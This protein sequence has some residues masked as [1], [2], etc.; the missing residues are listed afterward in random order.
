MTGAVSLGSAQIVSGT[1]GAYAQGTANLKTASFSLGVNSIK[2][3]FAGTKSDAT[4]TSSAKT[5]TVTG[6]YATT[7]GLSGTV[8]GTDFTL[9]A[10]LR[11]FGLESP[12]GNVDFSHISNGVPI[13]T[14][15]TKS[16]TEAK[17][18]TDLSISNTVA[19]FGT[20]SFYTDSIAVGDFDGDGLLDVAASILHSAGNPKIVILPGNGDGSFKPPVSFIDAGK[21]SLSIYAADV[22][23]DGRLDL[24]VVEGGG[25]AEGGSS[26]IGI[27]LGNGDGTFQ[28]EVEY[29]S[30]NRTDGFMYAYI[31][32]LNRD[33]NLDIVSASQNSAEVS[34]VVLLGNGDGTFQPQAAYDAGGAASSDLQVVGG[35]VNGDGI[36]DLVVNAKDVGD[37]VSVLLGKGDGSFL[38]PHSYKLG[39]SYLELSLEVTLADVNGDGKLDIVWAAINGDIGVAPGTGDGS[40][41]TA[42]TYSLGGNAGFYP[43]GKPPVVDINQDG[44][45]D[46]VVEVEN[47]PDAQM[48][49]L[50]GKGDGTFEQPVIYLQNVG[51]AV[52]GESNFTGPV[53]AG[54]FNGDGRLDLVTMNIPKNRVITIL[55]QQTASLQVAKNEL[56]PNTTTVQASYAGDGNFT[57]SVSSAVPLSQGGVD[58][59][60]GFTGGGAGL[61]LNDGAAVA[62]G[63]LQLTNGGVNRTTSAYSATPVNIRQFVTDFTFQMSNA[64]PE[65]LTFVIQ[66][67]GP[68]AVGSPGGGLG[69][70]GIAK[71]IG[72]KFD[73]FNYCATA[74]DFQ[75]G[76][77]STGLYVDGPNLADSCIGL[78]SNFSNVNLGSGNP[79]QAHITY[80]GVYL[81]MTLTDTVTLATYGFLEQIDIPYKVAGSTAYVGF[82]GATGSQSATATIRSWRYLAETPPPHFPNYY[83]DA[84]FQST[85]ELQFNGTSVL[86]QSPYSLAGTVALTQGL[87]N[88]AGSIFYSAPQ[89]V[90]AFTTDFTF[91]VAPVVSLTPGYLS[92]VADGITFTIQN[93][94]PKALGGPGGGLG[95]RDI[96]KSVAIKFDFLNNSGEGNASTGLYLNG[97][98]PTVPAVDLTGSDF[99]L[100]GTGGE[101]NAHMTYDGAILTLTMVNKNT[102]PST[103]FTHSW[104]VDIPAAVGGTTA[105]VGFTGATGSQFSTD[106]L[107]SWT[108]LPGVN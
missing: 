105:Y 94:G 71:S 21:Y 18:G 17:W 106:T 70:Q 61:H 64:G 33:G 63:V 22:N 38:P 46:I 27:L 88:Q 51:V 68:G 6:K 100:L 82:T 55:N 54:D 108:Y 78:P 104:A 73:L 15:D 60:G 44:K 34:A 53:V 101:F 57:G 29:G 81:A 89:N 10:A 93:N 92:N 50:A 76:A 58:Y 48:D 19:L 5:V 8:T 16:L 2:A 85:A 91:E 86:E 103:T 74:N 45:L 102:H 36:L 69:Y 47:G 90:E 66:N 41:Q 65:G 83:S 1:S 13:E 31:G 95:Y 99:T 4:S 42:H 20:V 26:G 23:N 30:G 62:G 43:V 59:S 39:T 72:I 35:D 40:F 80:D 14:I 52:S 79:I 11:A 32:D 56:G 25:P 96:P 49:L 24:V 3:V 12:T 77:D 107:Q 84:G 7:T 75:G 98:S 87:G 9:T 67:V 28:P 37:G 97:A